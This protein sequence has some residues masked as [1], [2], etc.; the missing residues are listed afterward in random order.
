VDKRDKL[1]ELI[2]YVFFGVLTTL[3]NLVVYQGLEHFLKPLWGGRSYLFS[4]VAAFVLALAFAF[5]VNKLFVFRQKSWER[6]LVL[7]ELLTF[8]AA[9]LVSFVFMEYIAVIIAFELIWPK[10]EPGFTAWWLRVWP[11]HWPEIT[12]ED[13]FRFIALWCF[14]Q[15]IVVVLNY[16]FSKFIVFRTTPACGHPSKEGNEMEEEA[17]E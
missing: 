14:I 15:V 11:A 13:A 17:A 2:V 8:S 9:R 1:R 10:A 12:P 4:R 7:H 16:I 6:H 5:V 3:V